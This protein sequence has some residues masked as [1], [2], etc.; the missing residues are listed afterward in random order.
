MTSLIFA[1]S[2]VTGGGLEF[3]PSVGRSSSRS[4]ERFAGRGFP[5][6]EVNSAVPRETAKQPRTK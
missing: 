3:P 6:Q 4:A 5:W 1:L 2:E